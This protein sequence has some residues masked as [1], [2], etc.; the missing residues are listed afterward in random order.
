ME[1]LQNSMF[2]VLQQPMF[3][4]PL[5][6]NPDNPNNPDNPITL[7]PYNPTA[8][9][10]DSQSVTRH[11]ERGYICLSGHLLEDQDALWGLGFIGFRGLAIRGLGL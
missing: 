8:P 4:S 6:L 5:P 2:K 11:Q 9:V 1:N 7:T 3:F 10:S